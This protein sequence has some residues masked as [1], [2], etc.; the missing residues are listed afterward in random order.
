MKQRLAMHELALRG[1]SGLYK[2]STSVTQ[3]EF[4]DYVATLNLETAFPAIHGIGY[5]PMVALP[6]KAAFVLEMQR[7][8][9]AGYA[10]R[11]EG[12]RAFYAPLAFL[13]PMNDLNRLVIGFDLNSEP[14][15]Q[16]ALERARDTGQATMTGKLVLT[17]SAG[18]VDEI[19]VILYLPIYR[20]GSRIE[21]LAQRRAN[22]I[23]WISAPFHLK[24]LL[25]LML[26]EQHDKIDVR[27]FDTEVPSADALMFGVMGA[28]GPQQGEPAQYQSTSHIEVSG[29]PWT[30]VFSSLPAFERGIDNSMVSLV[31]VSGIVTSFLLALLTF[32]FMRSRERAGRLQESEERLAVTLNSIGDAVVA[33]DAAGRVTL[34]NPQAER[35]IGWTI[36]QATGQRVDEVVVLLDRATRCSSPVP[37]VEALARGVPQDLHSPTLLISRD[38][39]E[40]M[41]ADSCGPIKDLNG[42]VAGAVMVFRDVGKE[43][44][45]QQALTDQQFYTRSLI[46]SNI[47]ALMTTNPDGMITDVNQ[48]METLTACRRVLQRNP[49]DNVNQIMISL[50]DMDNLETARK[51]ITAVIRE[52]HHL[53]ITADDDFTIR[54]MTE[55]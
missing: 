46:E 48:Q 25:Y 36:Q 33:T 40:S 54:D 7:Q 38:G 13:E 42:G 39:G 10:I 1:V 2:A 12:T 6:K 27:V 14:M 11:P 52:R 30:I 18:K 4:R 31:R 45:A 35:L 5:S 47:D 23:G 44:A 19:S 55:V 34:L 49:F 51:E 8:G 24:K 41:I 29:R 16:A 50:D 43:Y 20:N 37:I 32:L 17:Q 15:R 53:A 3:D 9:L 22:I 21:T 26:G 28:P